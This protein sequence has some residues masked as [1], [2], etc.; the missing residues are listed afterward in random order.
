MA[1]IDQLLQLFARSIFAKANALS[2]LEKLSDKQRSRLRKSISDDIRTCG[3][4]IFPDVVSPEVSKDAQQEA[5][6]IEINLCKE[7]WY[8]QVKFDRRREMFHWEHVRPVSSIQKMCEQAKS[9]EAIQDNLKIRLRIAWI[10]KREDDELT[11][12]RYRSKRV[13]P[14]GAYRDAK[15]KLLKF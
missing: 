7:N 4:F 2:R 10:L 8:T 1:T 6:R 3:G 9:E 13:D 5:K 15:I 14:D 11:R 12:L